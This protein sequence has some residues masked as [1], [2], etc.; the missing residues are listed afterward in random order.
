MVNIA[1]LKD[2]SSEIFELQPSLVK[3]Q[4]LPQKDKEALHILISAHT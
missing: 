4:S 2:T 3:G 1:H